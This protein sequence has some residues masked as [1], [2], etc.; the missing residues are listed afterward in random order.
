M[1]NGNDNI[2]DSTLE[3]LEKIG[4]I[5]MINGGEAFR[6]TGKYSSFEEICELKV[7]KEKFENNE[8][9]CKLTEKLFNEALEQNDYGIALE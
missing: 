2:Y 7:A 9:F 8:N 4:A 1:A 3:F 6:D 5:E